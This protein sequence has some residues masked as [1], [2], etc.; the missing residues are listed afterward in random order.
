MLAPLAGAHGLTINNLKQKNT[1]FHFNS[2]VSVL[3]IQF[4]KL[5]YL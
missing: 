5:E 4:Y 3:E 2:F 1:T